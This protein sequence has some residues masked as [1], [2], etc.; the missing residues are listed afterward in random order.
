MSLATDKPEF[1][2]PK[3][4]SGRLRAI[5]FA[6]LAHAILIAALTWGVGWKRESSNAP[7][8]AELWS[9]TVQEAAPAAVEPPPPPPAPPQP[10]V[11]QVNPEPPKAAEPEP[12][13]DPQIAIEKEKEKKIKLEK[14]KKEKALAKA[15]AEEEAEEKRLEELAKKKK[16]D[17]KK[18]AEK[19][20]NDTKEAKD[21]AK[22]E[23]LRKANLERIKGLAG[24]SGG[25][26]ATGTALQ[27]T[28]PSAGYGGR[29]IA[30]I[31]PNI[32]F[33]DDVLGNPVA[34]VEVRCAPDGTILARKLIKSSGNSAWDNAVLRA[35]DKT[36]ILPRDIDGRVPSSFEINFR[37]RD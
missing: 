25:P 30:R 22:A 37:P 7:I 28:G 33:T 19:K 3:Q 35:I 24:A 2:P 34:T 4:N 17:A 15:K 36:E 27:S 6:V 32:V 10:L 1:I 29:V 23:A 31:K 12:V 8:Q 9:T 20:A 21:V 14:I 16:L 18:A 13:V 26:Q 5:G 11:E